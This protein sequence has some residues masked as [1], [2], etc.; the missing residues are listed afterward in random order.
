MADAT[1]TVEETG[2]CAGR[3]VA[4][5]RPSA[6]RRLGLEG[7]HDLL[8]SLL[9]SASEAVPECPGRER[10]RSW[11]GESTLGV[12]R[13][14]SENASAQRDAEPH[15]RSSAQRDAEPHAR[16]SGGE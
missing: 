6:F 7:C 4:R 14:R 5:G 1:A 16:A 2:K 3:D 12:L 9:T 8:N 10:V 13:L 11:L 15:A